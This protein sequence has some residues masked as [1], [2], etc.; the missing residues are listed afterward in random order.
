VNLLFSPMQIK[1]ITF[2]NRV[3]MP[4]MVTG[5]ADA[6][7]CVTERLLE[8]Y[9]RRARAGTALIIVEATYVDERGRCWERGLGA[10]NHQ[11][12]EGLSALARR[13]HEGGAVAAIQLVHG[14]PQA[15]A[16]VSG[17]PTV[18]PSSVR[19]SSDA[20]VPREL[21]TEEMRS[22]QVLFGQAAARAVAAGFDAVEVHGAHGFLLDSFLSA[23][24]NQRRDSYGGGIQGRMR[25][26]VET[27]ERVKDQIR[28]RALLLCR[29]SVFNKIAEGF[30]WEDFQ[31]LIR[32]LGAAGID[33]L[34][35]STEGAFKGYFGDGRS[36][37]QGA[38]ALVSLPVIVAGG[39]GDPAEAERA[40]AE[41]HCDF[42]AVG[43]GMMQDPEWTEHARQALAQRGLA[44]I[45]DTRS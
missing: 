36:V 29:L 40:I 26:L 10:A 9:G 7:G 23:A 4:P 3:V 42:A 18:G 16:E 12:L 31:A 45:P 33:I 37:G 20:P 32:G 28:D 27:C 41:G 15:S 22:I 21:T 8:H 5:K 44:M 24:R 35:I 25:M 11:H 13:I 17:A 14:G 19:P 39:L 2:R 43:S 34:H 6:S 38:K 1:S 30:S